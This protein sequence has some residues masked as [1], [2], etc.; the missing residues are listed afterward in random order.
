M[1]RITSK[2]FIFMILKTD[3]MLKKEI[4]LLNQSRIEVEFKELKSLA[5]PRRFIT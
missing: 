3:L 4:K 2:S 5:G 1:K